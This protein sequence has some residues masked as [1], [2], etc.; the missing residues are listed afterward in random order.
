MRTGLGVVAAPVHD[1]ADTGRQPDQVD[2][3]VN[4]HLGWKLHPS[5]EPAAV[6]NG[7]LTLRSH[8]HHVSLGAPRPRWAGRLVV[9]P[10]GGPLMPEPG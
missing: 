8:H 9:P 4:P 2:D 3:E 6:P 7:F 1:G 10:L 5:T